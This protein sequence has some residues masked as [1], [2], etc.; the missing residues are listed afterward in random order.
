MFGFLFL[1]LKY[2]PEQLPA[3]FEACK[4]T[5]MA[6]SLEDSM[7]H[8]LSMEHSPLPGTTAE[9]G[10]YLLPSLHGRGQ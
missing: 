2:F 1:F 4:I 9:P 10:T 7:L 3:S 5:S 6:V 8:P